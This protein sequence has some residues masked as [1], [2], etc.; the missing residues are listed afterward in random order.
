[1]G[2]LDGGAANFRAEVIHRLERIEAQTTATN[3]RVGELERRA[4]R[5]EGAREARATLLREEVERRK[6]GT[7]RRHW[8]WDA[9][10]AFTGAAAIVLATLGASGKL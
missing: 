9:F 4:E 7:A 6:D 3:G 8:R 2:L 1:M 5:E 10:F